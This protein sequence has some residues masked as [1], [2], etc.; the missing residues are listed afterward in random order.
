MCWL[1]V[2]F[3]SFCIWPCDMVH[4]DYLDYNPN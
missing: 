4:I 2:I 1:M 3:D